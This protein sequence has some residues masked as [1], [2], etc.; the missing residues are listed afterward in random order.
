VSV[1]RLEDH[2][3]GKW[4]TAEA[5]CSICAEE[6]VAVIPA[7]HTGALECPGCRQMSGQIAFGGW[8]DREG[9][10]MLMPMPASCWVTPT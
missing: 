7:A 8:L 5:A 10:V 3:P 2:A 9:N 6:W 1:V 4:M